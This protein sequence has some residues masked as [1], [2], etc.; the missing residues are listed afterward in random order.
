MVLVTFCLPVAVFSAGRTW[1]LSSPDGRIN[2]EI[3]SDGKVTYSISFDGKVILAPS[4]ISMSL[5]DGRIFG[6]GAVRSIKTGSVAE[7][8]LPAIA[9]KE[10]AVDNVYNWL[11]LNFRDCAI[12][13]RAFDDAVA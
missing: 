7:H 13:F 11:T 10:A 1:T 12:E 9:Y 3:R 6:E 4:E 2:A 8:G 5:G